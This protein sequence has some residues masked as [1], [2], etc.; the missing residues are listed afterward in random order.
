VQAVT[1]HNSIQPSLLKE[2]SAEVFRL[3]VRLFCSRGGFTPGL[4]VPDKPPSRWTIEK[5]DGRRHPF[6]SLRALR[7]PRENGSLAS[8]P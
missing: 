2:Y 5:E 1:P 4:K 6:F 8:A 3:V 7:S